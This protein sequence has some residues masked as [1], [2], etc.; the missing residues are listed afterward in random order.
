[1]SDQEQEAGGAGGE[2]KG[3][4]EAAA[5]GGQGGGQGGGVATPPALLDQLS[6][7]YRTVAER[8]SFKTADDLA[9][10]YVN[11]EAKLG[12][13]KVTLPKKSPEGARDFSTWEGWDALGRPKEATGY[14]I[15]A[16]E[17]R[18]FSDQDKAFH[19]AMR[20][21]LHKAGITQAQLDAL[22]PGWSEVMAGFAAE[23]ESAVSKQV[24]ETEAALKKEWGAQFQTRMNDANLAAEKLGGQ[25]LVAALDELG[26]GRSAPVLKA[27]AKV[28]AMLRED[29][30]LGMVTG[31]G[32]MGAAEAKAKIA[33]NQGDRSFLERY[34]D[35]SHPGHQ[36]AVEE[37][38]RLFNIAASGKAA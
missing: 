27:M 24:D 15:K 10:A 34:Q 14:E 18:E 22:A 11:L 4:G 6:G 16:P 20:P 25:D 9:K 8:N 5:K 30:K 19:D 2:G 29:G 23:R 17:G 36:A 13:D 33:A 32:E 12:A 21:H 28:G 37:M 26:M 7:D 1:M 38:Q 35:R 31:G 3:G